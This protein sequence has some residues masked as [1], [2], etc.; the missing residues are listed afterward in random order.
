MNCHVRVQAVVDLVLDA[1][2][3]PARMT[4]TKEQALRGVLTTRRCLAARRGLRPDVPPKL[5]HPTRSRAATLF[6]G[7]T[8]AITPVQAQD[9]AV[10]ERYREPVA[11]LRGEPFGETDHYAS[12]TR[13]AW[14][15]QRLVILD[16]K[17]DRMITI[18]DERT[19]RTVQRFGRR[20]S[21]PGEFRAP[22]DLA[23][24]VSPNAI[25]IFDTSLRR[26]TLVNLDSSFAN[27][28]FTPVRMLK[29][30]GG[31]EINSVRW[32]ADGALL[33]T[34]TLRRGLF[35][36]FD[37]SGRELPARGEFTYGDRRLPISALQEA[38]SSRLAT[39]PRRERVAL[40]MD[41]ADRLEFFALSGKRLATN[42]RPF[43][44]EPTYV[45]VGK[46]DYRHAAFTG[47]SR[48]G[49][50]GV[51]AT[52][53]S[54]FALF[55]GRRPREF[56]NDAMF[57]RHVHVYS[58]AGVLRSVLELD[59][60]AIDIAVDPQARMLYTLVHDP[61]PRVVRYRLPAFSRAEP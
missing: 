57:G 56:K 45:V 25:W 19:G 43:G 26:M 11:R 46:G 35:A 15:N 29:L 28:T 4:R 9:A 53:T 23:P 58:W 47:H 41:Y 5:Q 54:V 24:A 20:G 49:Y 34:G 8:L 22:W 39:D 10:L 13:I 61:E 60:A 44:F 3:P 2:I 16:R 42:Q 32:I 1:R 31:T 17:A 51:D 50:R 38:Y 33:G 55:S 12:P 6:L 27:G 36:A 37:T 48:E 18:L 40:A 7:L 14:V 30:G 59:A 52:S 21:G